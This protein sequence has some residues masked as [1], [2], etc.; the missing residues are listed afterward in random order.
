VKWVEGIVPVN[1]AAPVHP[2]A[3][4]MRNTGAVVLAAIVRAGY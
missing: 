1:T 3:N 4:G 2:N